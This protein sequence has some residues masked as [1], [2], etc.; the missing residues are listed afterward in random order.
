MI[1]ID[2]P[3]FRN[4]VQLTP[5]L[6]DNGQYMDMDYFD[7]RGHRFTVRGGRLNTTVCVGVL[8]ASGWKFHT[9]DDRFYF[10]TD[11]N[12]ES[13][14]LSMRYM[15]HLVTMLIAKHQAEV[16]KSLKI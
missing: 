6:T 8:E 15:R 13:I 9:V 2:L 10:F 16:T 1:D 7:Y 3:S 12:G 5:V 11:P 14:H 4:S